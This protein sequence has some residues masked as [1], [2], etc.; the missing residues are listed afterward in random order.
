MGR[1]PLRSLD[2]FSGIGGLIL[3][4]QGVAEPS[5]FCDIDPAAQGIS[6][7]PNAGQRSPRTAPPAP[8]V[9][10]G[11]E[12]VSVGQ[13]LRHLGP[14]VEQ[15]LSSGAR[16]GQQSKGEGGHEQQ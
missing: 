12:E 3:A 14:A 15:R 4:L 10:S 8:A 1:K 5:A 9:M 2:L 16:P 7:T 13:A 6:H 11:G